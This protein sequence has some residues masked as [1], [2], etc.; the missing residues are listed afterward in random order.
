MPDIY[1]ATRPH[2]C[3]AHDEGSWISDWVPDGVRL[4]RPVGSIWRCPDCRR[5][6]VKTKYIW[7]PVRWWNFNTRW[8]CR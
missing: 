2:V 5:Y 7:K 3:T 1:V 4:I 6:W 8:R